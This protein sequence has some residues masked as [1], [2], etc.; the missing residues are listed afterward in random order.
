[1]SLAR[2]PLISHFGASIQG[3]ASIRAYGAQDTFIDGIA[4]N[5]LPLLLTLTLILARPPESLKRID[6][7]SRVAR[8]YWTLNR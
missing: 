4:S 8:P 3:L 6:R 5:H 2:A 1:M 7:Y